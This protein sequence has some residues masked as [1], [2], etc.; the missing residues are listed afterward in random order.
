MLS[1]NSGPDTVS[2][3]LQRSYPI[4]MRSCSGLARIGPVSGIRD[5]HRMSPAFFDLLAD[6]PK[7]LCRAVA[8]QT[9]PF[10]IDR[11]Q[12]DVQ[13]ALFGDHSAGVGIDQFKSETAVGNVAVEYGHPDVPGNAAVLI[14]TFHDLRAG[15]LR[16][17]E[18]RPAGPDSCLERHLGDQPENIRLISIPQDLTE[19]QCPF[20]QSFRQS[21][22]IV[23][24]DEERIS[25]SLNR[26]SALS[27]A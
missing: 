16:I 6:D 11:A 26:I 21:K 10:L 14:D 12:K 5:M 8:P 20:I 24:A 15:F 22:L 23:R 17:R 18:Q 9:V 27:S 4:L 2:A 3:I 19:L 13:P 1:S 7:L 25:P